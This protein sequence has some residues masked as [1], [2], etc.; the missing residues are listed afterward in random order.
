MTIQRIGGVRAAFA[1][2]P[3]ALRALTFAVHAALA[4][5]KL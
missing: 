3:L 2:L 1:M 4:R 5:R